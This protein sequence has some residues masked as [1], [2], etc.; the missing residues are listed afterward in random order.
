[1]IITRYLALIQTSLEPDEALPLLDAFNHRWWRTAS[2]T[3]ETDVH[4]GP[5]CV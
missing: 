2:A 5:D 3:L 4:L 1:V